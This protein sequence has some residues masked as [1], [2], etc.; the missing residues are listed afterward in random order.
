MII[1]FHLIDENCCIYSINKRVIAMAIII[2]SIIV[3]TMIILVIKIIVMIIIIMV[4]FKHYFSR[5]HVP[6]S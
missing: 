2:I 4:I 6:C 1:L 3:L 5:E